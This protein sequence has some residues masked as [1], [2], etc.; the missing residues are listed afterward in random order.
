MPIVTFDRIARQISSEVFVISIPR[1]VYGTHIEPKSLSIYCN[2]SLTIVDNGE[3]SLY[4]EN[5]VIPTFV[6]DVI[7]NQGMIILTDTDAISEVSSSLSTLDIDFKSN[8]PIYSY[9]VYC[10]VRDTEMNFTYNKTTLSGSNGDI[11]PELL[12]EWGTTLTPYITTIGL[13]NNAHEL[14]A[15][16]KLNMPIRKSLSSDM[17]FVVNFDI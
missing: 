11:T 15:V 2:P 1:D 9:N 14:V 8:L 10:T 6:G 4:R 16:G 5:S 7:Y 12:S 17:T 3:G 13:Y